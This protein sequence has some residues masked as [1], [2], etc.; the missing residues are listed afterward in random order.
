MN[1]DLN[2]LLKNVEYIDI[3]KQIE[4]NTEQNTIIFGSN[5]IGK[6]TIYHELKNQYPSFDYLDYDETKDLFKKNKKKIEL[7]LGINKLE[8]LSERI[9]KLDEVLSI[10]NRLKEKK[11][12]SKA[13]AQE[14]SSKLGEKYVSNKFNKIEIAD[15]EFDKIKKI[16]K[17]INF[18]IKN[19]NALKEI[20]DIT[21]EL[22]LVDQNYLKKAL[23]LLDSE[24]DEETKICPI[25]NSPVNDLKSIIKNKL[26]ALSTIKNNCLTKFVIEN[27][28]KLKNDEIQKDFLAILENIKNIKEENIIDYFIVNGDIETIKTVNNALEEKIKTIKELKECLEKQEQ[29]FN[30]LISQKAMYT[31]YLKNNFEA[32]VE[33]DNDKKIVTISFKRNVET[34]STGEINLILFITK[35]F[36]FL[37]SD[38]Q[39]LI[40]DDPISSYDLVN[41]YHIVFHL[42]KII[43]SHDKH[44]IVFTHNPDVINIINSQNNSAYTY[45]F[46]DKVKN[47]IIMNALP[48]EMRTGANVLFIDNLTKDKKIEANRYLSLMISRN[49]EDPS[50]KLSSILHYDSTFVTLG[51]DCE[52]FKGCTNKYFIDYIEN[53]LYINDLENIEFEKLCRAKI[54]S[55][56]SIRVWIEYK[57]QDIS[58]VKLEGLFSNKINTFF[59]K[60]ID[61]QN[62][63]PHLTKE[64][65]MNKKVMLNQNCH[66]KSQVQPFYY[67]LSIKTDDI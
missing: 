22:K 55:L 9:N 7:S 38:K 48:T 27:E 63:Y 26:K 40:I 13:K 31:D 1:I 44:V 54:V 30:S 56:A 67:A 64:C 47:K 42:C 35:L 19:F 36:S 66:I 24:V 3:D 34:F 10:Q 21:S 58:S 61:I 52:E 43:A 23:L 8:E 12:T 59:K 37:G 29:L 33:F 11:I 20:D 65:L 2:N 53:N 60:N 4:I 17:N 14:M 15:D 18:I 32:D 25:C 46:F 5:G 41:Q 6:T 62:S 16:D 51:D 49:D 45:L 57:L 28:Y 39:L 50:D